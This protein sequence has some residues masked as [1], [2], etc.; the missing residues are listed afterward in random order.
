MIANKRVNYGYIGDYYV[1]ASKRSQFS[2]IALSNVHTFALTK[3]FMF[4]EI[5]KKF[6][7]L[8]S[9]MLAESFSRYIK[10]F[11]KPCGKKRLETIQSHNKRSAYSKISADNNRGGKRVSGQTPTQTKPGS[12]LETGKK[13]GNTL[14]RSNSRTRIF[15]K[16]E[17]LK[18][19]KEQLDILNEK[20]N[21]MFEHMKQINKLVNKKIMD[22]ENAVTKSEAIFVEEINNLIKNK[23]ELQKIERRNYQNQRI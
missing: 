2:Y 22:I 1:F 13:T 15:E 18:Q 4:K 6:P 3:K 10:E 16:Q 5:F 14:Q 8:H 12:R 7:G 23:G 11:R 20:A 21:T 9:E 17:E 19:Y